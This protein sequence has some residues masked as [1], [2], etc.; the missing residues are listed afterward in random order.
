M[1]PATEVPLV[2]LTPSTDFSPGAFDTGD[3]TAAKTLASFHIQTD[4]LRSQSRV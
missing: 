3:K 1:T 2:F 4:K